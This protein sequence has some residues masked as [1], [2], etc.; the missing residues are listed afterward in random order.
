MKS[1]LSYLVEYSSV[2]TSAGVDSFARG[3]KILSGDSEAAVSTV[4]D[5]GIGAAKVPG[6]IA[7]DVANT[8][9]GTAGL[10]L[11][12]GT[13]A[14]RK[15]AEMYQ[16]RKAQKEQKKEQDYPYPE[17]A[18]QNSASQKPVNTKLDKFLRSQ[19]SKYTF[20]ENEYLNLPTVAPGTPG[21]PNIPRRASSIAAI[22]G[23]RRMNNYHTAADRS[24][25]LMLQ[26]LSNLPIEKR[27][28]ETGYPKQIGKLAA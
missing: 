5:L 25:L 26:K 4:K 22:F 11:I 27:E 6:W 1:V 10:G 23:R 13:L 24:H 3:I 28:A 9:V 17:L 20:T 16:N 7:K 14:A 15:L 12:G 19:R 8:T 2:D 21:L 18:P